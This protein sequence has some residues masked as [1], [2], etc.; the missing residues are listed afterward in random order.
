[1]SDV[2]TSQPTPQSTA[3]LLNQVTTELTQVVSL[4]EPLINTDV[5][6]EAEITSLKSQLA[7]ATTQLQTTLAADGQN[8]SALSQL[9]SKLQDVITAATAATNPSSS[10]APAPAPAPATATIL[11]T[12]PTPP[13]Y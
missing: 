9:S 8:A 3:D 4:L 7:S 2:S 6:Q 1:M 10:T 5:S 12:T 13:T 11:G